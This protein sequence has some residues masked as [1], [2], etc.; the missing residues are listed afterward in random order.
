MRK[1]AFLILS[2]ALLL[3]ACAP[4]AAPTPEKMMAAAPTAE[5]MME[6]TPTADKMMDASPTADKMMDATPA[7]DKMMDAAPAW[8]SASLTDVTTGAA[9]TI[10][11]FKGKVVLVETMAQW[12]PTCKRQQQAARQDSCAIE[13]AV[14]RRNRQGHDKEVQPATSARNFEPARRNVD[15]VLLE[16]D[17]DAEQPRRAA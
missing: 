7:A 9:F 1:L 3:G 4:A 16:Y 6:T 17:R 10:Q 15:D 5:K 14:D 11:D 12:C 2:T 13:L 8:Y